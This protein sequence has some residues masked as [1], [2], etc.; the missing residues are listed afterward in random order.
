[1]TKFEALYGLKSLNVPYIIRDE[2]DQ[3]IIDQTITFNQ[4]IN[5][6]RNLV[7]AYFFTNDESKIAFLRAFP[8]NEANG[9]IIFKEVKSETAPK[10]KAEK[11]VTEPV[12]PTADE[13]VAEPTAEEEP[14]AEATEPTESA[15]LVDNDVETVQQ[16][17]SLL[18]GMFSELKAKDTK[19]KE[20]VL[21][22]AKAKN[23]SFPNL[24]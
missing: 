15:T 8:G 3:V 17:S 20:Q 22:I 9:G 13:S 14:V 7:P 6:G 2:N 11:K 10:A 24:K 21:A 23:I 16:G 18:R 4:G 5:N 1:M 19:T 12:A